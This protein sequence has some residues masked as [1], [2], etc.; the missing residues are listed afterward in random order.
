MSM[1]IVESL[2]YMVGYEEMANN[3]CDLGTVYRDRGNLDRAEEM[4][5]K[6]MELFR[7]IRRIIQMSEV[8]DLLDDLRKRR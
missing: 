6:S 4:Y 2:G 8:E 7:K 3:Y 5:L 1:E